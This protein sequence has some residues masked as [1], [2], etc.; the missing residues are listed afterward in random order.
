MRKSQVKFIVH[1]WPLI[2]RG[3]TRS[4]CVGYLWENGLPLPDHSA[5]LCCPYRPASEWLKIKN[6]YPE[7]WR[8]AVEFD[9]ANRHNPLAVRGKSTADELYIY[10]AGVPLE[11]ADLEEDAAHEEDPQW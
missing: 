1:D 4:D 10:K 3:M 9:N 6:K 2:R 5:C 7:D 11:D 8:A